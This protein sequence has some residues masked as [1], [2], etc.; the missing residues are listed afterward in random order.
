M[1]YGRPGKTTRYLKK[2]IKTRQAAHRSKVRQAKALAKKSAKAQTVIGKSMK[3]QRA[4]DLVGSGDWEW[5]G[6]G[7]DP[8]TIVEAQWGENGWEYVPA[9]SQRKRAALTAPAGGHPDTCRGKTKDGSPCQRIGKCPIASH[10]RNK[11]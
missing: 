3:P 1:P 6:S 8:D 7:M 10:K 11:V 9:K 2:F 4:G 5:E